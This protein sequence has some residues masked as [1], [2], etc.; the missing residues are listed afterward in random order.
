MS[1]STGRC[2]GR[3]ARRTIITDIRRTGF[4]EQDK[5]AIWRQ[6]RVTL[7]P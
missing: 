5:W 7:L 6:G 4:I 3:Q 2:G 1:A